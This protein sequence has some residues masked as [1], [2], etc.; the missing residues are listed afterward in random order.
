A[1]APLFDGAEVIGSVLRTQPGIRPVYVSV[2]HKIDLPGAEQ[3]VLACATRYRLPEPTRLAD[4][5]VAAV[6]RQGQFTAQK[7]GSS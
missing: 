7:V 1:R 3:L 4:Q 5:F 6:K 2:G